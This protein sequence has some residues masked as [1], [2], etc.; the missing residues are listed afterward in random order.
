MN[1]AI[2]SRPLMV[3]RLVTSATQA[4]GATPQRT[5]T[6]FPVVGG[7]FE[8]Y[9]VRGRVL[10]GGDWV[11]TLGDG[12]FLLDLRVT[13]ETSLGSPHLRKTR[14]WPCRKLPGA[15][16]TAEKPAAPSSSVAA[17]ERS[18]VLAPHKS[19]GLKYLCVVPPWAPPKTRLFG[20]FIIR[21]SS[22]FG[23]RIAR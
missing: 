1:V 16:Q 19:M 22:S 11:S 7:S 14:R 13:L 6:I 10:S 12:V 9:R 20:S 2:H 23:T 21:I 3:L 15:H 18:G 4:I 5:L 17:L 8:G